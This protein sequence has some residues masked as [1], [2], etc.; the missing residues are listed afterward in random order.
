[1]APVSR[2]VVLGDS[3]TWGQGL[4]PQHKFA[5]LVG[6]ALGCAAPPT[7]IAHSGAVIGVG[8]NSVPG[9]QSGEIPDS[10]PTILAQVAAFTDNPNTVDLVM[11]DG[12]INDVDVRTILSP[13]TSF[14]ALGDR[15][16]LHCYLDMKQLLTA[17]VAKFPNPATRIVV[18]SYYPILSG[19]SDPLRIPHLLSVRGVPLPEF[20]DADPLVRK[21]VSL[22]LQFWHDSE[23]WLGRAVTETNAAIGGNRIRFAVPQFTEKNS[24]FAS[25]AWLWGLKLDLSPQDEVVATRVPACDVFYQGKPDELLACAQCHRASA[26]HPNVTGASQ[27]A[28]AI[29]QA[30]A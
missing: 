19:D 21:I 27:F 29:E 18:T 9:A 11:I 20:L 1:M 28:D 17:V 4:L 13:L 14:A 23:M 2:I 16:K 12:G 7:F 3:V 22:C 8:R 25:E 5:S 24:V 30:L 26:G 10:Y 15:T 6:Q